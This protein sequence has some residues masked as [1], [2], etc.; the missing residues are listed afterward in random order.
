MATVTSI[1]INKKI[2]LNKEVKIPYY[3]NNYT[4][5]EGTSLIDILDRCNDDDKLELTIKDISGIEH[6]VYITYNSLPHCCGV[7]ELGELSTSK[8]IPI[9]E[10]TKVLDTIVCKNNNFTLIINTNGINDS[11]IFEKA[12][13]KCK[14][15]N[16]VKSFKN[17]NSKNTIKMWVSNND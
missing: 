17:A 12:L 6:E 2:V 13:S 4:D 9:I 5:N 3:T 15:F 14:Y 11:I 1:K 16:L 10:L 8:N 7:Y